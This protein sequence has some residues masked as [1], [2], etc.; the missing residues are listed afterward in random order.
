MKR[1]LIQG[2]HPLPASFLFIIDQA[3]LMRL[4]SGDCGGQFIVWIQFFSFHVLKTLHALLHK[5]FS[6]F[7]MYFAHTACFIF[8]PSG[9][10]AQ[11]YSF[12]PFLVRSRNFDLRVCYATVRAIMKLTNIL[13]VADLLTF[14]KKKMN[15]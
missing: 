2:E 4:S 14:N 15:Y 12:K 6:V 11:E 1:E 8:G 13:L 10:R 7:F 9:F 5:L 3:F